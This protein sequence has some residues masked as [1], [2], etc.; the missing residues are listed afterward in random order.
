MP[1]IVA[2]MLKMVVKAYSILMLTYS[3]AWVGFLRFVGLKAGKNVRLDGFYHWPWR[4]L[5][6]L[7]LRDNVRLGDR[8]KFI[9]GEDE[10]GIVV[11][12]NAHLSGAF[13][14]ISGAPIVIGENCVFSF[15]IAIIST[16]HKLGVGIDPVTSGMVKARPIKLGN[17]CFL[18]CNTTILEGVTLGDDCVVGAGAVVTKSFP[19]GSVI[20]GVPARLIKAQ[21]S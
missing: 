16:A 21:A 1:L 12:K 7:E 4:R 6:Q 18:G 5:S 3:V 13:T 8:G 11:G 17:R 19:A 14:I 9:I 20:G 2:V 15:N 10:G